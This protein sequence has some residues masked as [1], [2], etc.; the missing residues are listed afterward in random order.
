MAIERAIT[1]AAY[2]PAAIDTQVEK[3]SSIAREILSQNNHKLKQ[4]HVTF[5]N[6]GSE[7]KQV[8]EKLPPEYRDTV[9]IIAT[10]TTIILD[11]N[12]ACKVYNIIGEKDWPSRV[13]N[14]GTSGLDRKSEHAEIRMIPQTETKAIIGGHYFTQPDYQKRIEDIISKEIQGKYEIY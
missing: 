13:C 3:L 8:L 2:I 12:L 7:I 4:V 6:G 9:I 10:G 11:D 14:G 1:G 5:S